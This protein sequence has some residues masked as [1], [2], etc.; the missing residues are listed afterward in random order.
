MS[1][2]TCHYCQ[3]PEPWTLPL[4]TPQLCTGSWSAKEKRERNEGNDKT[5]NI[6]KS[7]HIWIYNLWREVYS[8]PWSG[9]SKHGQ[10]DRETDIATMVLPSLISQFGQILWGKTSD[11][12]HFFL[13]RATQKM[14]TDLDQKI[15]HKNYWRCKYWLSVF[16]H[17]KQ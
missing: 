13:V 8:A 5:A 16:E 15:S 10:T 12:A 17:L 3:Q 1:P 11:G 14:K 9:V 7:M 4:L 2:V 6:S